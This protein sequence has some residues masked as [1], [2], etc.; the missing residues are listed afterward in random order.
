MT[1][2]GRKYLVITYNAPNLQQSLSQNDTTVVSYTWLADGTK[3]A[4]VDNTTNVKL[5][6]TGKSGATNAHLHI[7][8]MDSEDNRIAPENI[9]YGSVTNQE[10]FTTYGGDYHKLRNTKEAKVN[11]SFSPKQNTAARDNTRVCNPWTL[12]S[13]WLQQN[14]NIKIT[15]I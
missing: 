11:E 2:D 4:V 12:I 1:T 14:P 6:V 3:C 7:D 13:S 15:V 8:P 5:G 10:F 9:N